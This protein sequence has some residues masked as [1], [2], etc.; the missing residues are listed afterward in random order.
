MRWCA[1]SVLDDAILAD[2]HLRWRGLAVRIGARGPT[3]ENETPPAIPL[4]VYVYI[5]IY[6]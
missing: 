1:E 6:T 2:F 4:S 5:Y 3:D